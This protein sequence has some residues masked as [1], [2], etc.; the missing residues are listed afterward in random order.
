MN[1]HH[2]NEI[3]S[4]YLKKFE[5]FA[6]FQAPKQK[7]YQKTTPP[8]APSPTS[9]ATPEEKIESGIT[10]L[11]S[12][13]ASEILDA[14]HEASPFFFERVVVELLVAMEVFSRNHRECRTDPEQGG[15]HRPPS[16][17]LGDDSLLLPQ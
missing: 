5:E 12:Q 11:N 10:E 4:A 3:S 13:L 6:V 17:Q 14:L 7:N 2:A 8:N 15:P 1:C 16:V 9:D